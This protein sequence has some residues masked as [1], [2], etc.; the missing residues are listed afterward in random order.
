M[1]HLGQATTAH[2]TAP[3][4][5]LIVAKAIS[6]ILVSAVKHQD[7]YWQNH[8]HSQKVLKRIQKAHRNY[9]R[10]NKLSEE[11]N[12]YPFSAAALKQM[13]LLL[14]R[15]PQAHKTIICDQE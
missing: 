2:V 6:R 4:S 3:L 15:R 8:N 14:N 9:K 1:L 5:I 13:I 11:R 7:L 10:Q 12:S